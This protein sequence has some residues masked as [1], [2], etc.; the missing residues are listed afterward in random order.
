MAHSTC[1]RTRKATWDSGFYF[2]ATSCCCTPSRGCLDLFPAFGGWKGLGSGPYLFMGLPWLCKPFSAFLLYIVFLGGAVTPSSEVRGL[3]GRRA[4][5]APASST[6]TDL[7][8]HSAQKLAEWHAGGP[9]RSTQGNWGPGY[10]PLAEH[11]RGPSPA[12]IEWGNDAATLAVWLRPDMQ[13]IGHLLPGMRHQV[14]SGPALGERIFGSGTYVDTAALAAAEVPQKPRKG[15]LHRAFIAEADSQG[16]AEGPPQREG[17]GQEL[18]GQGALG[19][20]GSNQRDGPTAPTASADSAANGCARSPEPGACGGKPTEVE[21]LLGA[22]ERPGQSEGGLATGR[23][24]AARDPYGLE[25]QIRGQGDAQI[26][27]PAGASQDRAF[28]RASMQSSVPAGVA[29]LPTEADRPLDHADEEEER[30][31]SV[32][33]RGRGTLGGTTACGG[34]GYANGL[35]H[36]YRGGVGGRGGH[37]GSRSR[38][39][40]GCG[41]SR[42]QTDRGGGCYGARACADGG[43]SVRDRDGPGSGAGVP[44]KNTEAFKRWCLPWLLLSAGQDGSG[45]SKGWFQ[46]G[47]PWQGP[48]TCSR[49]VTGPSALPRRILSS[50]VSEDDCV[51]EFQAPVLA[52]C[53][54]SE[55]ALHGCFVPHNPFTNADPRLWH[56][57]QFLSGGDLRDAGGTGGS[58]AFRCSDWSHGQRSV[59]VTDAASGLTGGRVFPDPAAVGTSERIVHSTD[60][61]PGLGASGEEGSAQRDKAVLILPR[62]TRSSLHV[63][64]HLLPLKVHFEDGGRH[65]NLWSRGLSDAVCSSGPADVLCPSPPCRSPRGGCFKVGSMSSL[66]TAFPSPL[67]ARPARSTGSGRLSDRVPYMDSSPPYLATTRASTSDN[68]ALASCVPPVACTR[69]CLATRSGL[70]EGAVASKVGSL[71]YL[72]TA[73]S[74]SLRVPPVTSTAS[75]R[76]LDCFSHV[77]STHHCLAAATGIP[78]SANSML[79]FRVPPVACTRACLANPSGPFEGAVASE[80]DPILSLGNARPSQLRVPPVAS[81]ASGQMSDR[82]A[83]AESSPPTSASTRALTSANS[84]FASCVPPVAGTSVCLA[85]PHGSIGGAVASRASS[86][87]SLDTAQSSPLRVPPVTSTATGRMPD[88]ILP[89]D[90]AHPR[91]AAATGAPTSVNHALASCVPPVACTSAC[92]ANLTGPSERAVAFKVGTLSSLA[93]TPS[94]VGCTAACLNNPVELFNGVTASKVGSLS[95]LAQFPPTDKACASTEVP[96]LAPQPT[97]QPPGLLGQFGPPRPSTIAHASPGSSAAASGTYCVSAL[98]N[99]YGPAQDPRISCR[100]RQRAS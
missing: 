79:A 2:F 27:A 20:C 14:G 6:Q 3:Q 13:G 100:V 33:R 96:P 88:S 26:G 62:A 70:S 87:S 90:S 46:G 93:Q 77:D 22:C 42:G 36:A 25:P 9:N 54:A 68:S 29:P 71:L 30:I 84:A 95:S 40:A 18:P 63:H 49:E 98:R 58:L 78:T 32:L 43:P 66:G 73:Q 48:V 37:G 21:G 19:C 51:V 97:T 39:L 56:G 41:S 80:V 75:G 8:A 99:T 86:F 67:Q 23:A 34:Q 11:P 10:T 53:L 45:Q 44:R 89:V 5:L 57:S 35:W 83:R 28:E 38:S 16:R 15:R 76:M 82:A 91:L 72:G 81:V 31:P 94:S 60:A 59:D 85:N 69:A 7:W 24:G 55:V 52:A 50:V 1:P 12:S 64:P 4:Q 61:F 65:Y 47:A 92:L 17:V 74:S